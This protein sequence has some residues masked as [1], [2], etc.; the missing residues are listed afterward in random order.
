[1]RIEDMAAL[2]IDR[3]GPLEARS[4]EETSGLRRVLVPVAEA[5]I[6][7][8]SRIARP[9]GLVASREV[10]TRTAGRLMRIRSWIAQR[11]PIDHEIAER[12]A[13]KVWAMARR[14]GAIRIGAGLAIVGLS[15][16]VRRLNNRPPAPIGQDAI[17]IRRIV[18]VAAPVHDV[19]EFWRRSENWPRV[20]PHVREVLEIALDRH[21]WTI[22][23][24]EGDPLE[25][26]TVITKFGPDR[27]IEWETVPASVVEHAGSIR[28]KENRNGTTR[29]DITMY[30]VPPAGAVGRAVAALFGRDPKTVMNEELAQFKSLLEQGQR[31]A[32][33]GAV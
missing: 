20:M 14:P 7:F 31:R 1:M 8:V 15:L 3:S 13:G 19:F 4:S 27:V 10:R 25:W 6:P 5:I 32:E 29:V 17:T 22:T 23:G 30:Y 28:F 16:L 12:M 2:Q 11:K 21:R 9:L 26:V 33:G 24:P 18:D